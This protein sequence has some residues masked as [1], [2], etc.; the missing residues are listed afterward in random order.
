MSRS[1]DG[2]GRTDWGVI[3]CVQQ[4]LW[5]EDR[6]DGLLT[7][8]K[9]RNTLLSSPSVSRH[10][11]AFYYV[12]LEHSFLEVPEKIL[13]LIW[14]WGEHKSLDSVEKEDFRFF[15]E[16]VDDYRLQMDLKEME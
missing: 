12:F 1:S 3:P 14:E 11:L 7:M 6:K 4:G 2:W 5:E 10:Y 9:F 16:L 13:R 8:G 15:E